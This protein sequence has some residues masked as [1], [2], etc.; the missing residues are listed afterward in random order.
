MRGAVGLLVACNSEA[1]GAGAPGE[2][3]EKAQAA[4]GSCGS[5][6]GGRACPHDTAADQAGEAGTPASGNT[7]SRGG[8]SSTTHGGKSGSGGTTSGGAASGGAASG[9]AAN[10][11]A[12]GAGGA[13]G[14]LGGKGGAGGAGGLGGGGAGGGD[15][16]SAIVYSTNFDLTELPIL[17]A[18]NWHHTGLEWAAIGTA[19]GLA[20]GNQALASR[21]ESEHYDDSYAYLSGFPGNHRA[22]ATVHRSSIDTGCTHEVEL[23]L[24]W[25]DAAHNAR[26]YECNLAYDGSY[27]GIVRWNGPYGDFTLLGNG[28]VAGGTHDG[29]VFSAEIVGSTITVRLNGSV[30][31]SA[32]DSVWTDGNPG[33]GLYRG[34]SGCGTQQDYGFASFAAT[35]L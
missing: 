14:G 26:G 17:E 34:L 18:G 22:T 8:D 6:S 35:S 7:A 32:S 10:G 16:G 24:R 30:V 12:A 33:I 31:V 4:S 23:L 25:S 3:G 11:G 2:G 19:N 21:P 29:D 5:A 9:G 13:A 1:E 27:A 28:T 20:Y 15:T